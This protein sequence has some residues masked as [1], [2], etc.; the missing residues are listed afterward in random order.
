VIESFLHRAK[1]WVRVLWFVLS[2]DSV[3]AFW[4]VSCTSR[5]IL[6]GRMLV[7][8]ASLPSAIS[9]FSCEGLVG[10]IHV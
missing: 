2:D 8:M 5:T 7:Q 9:S 4:F 10:P 3:T 1:M 6:A